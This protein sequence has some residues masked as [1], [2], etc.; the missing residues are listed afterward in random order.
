MI[1]VAE[2]V[3]RSWIDQRFSVAHIA[4][5]LYWS[6]VWLITINLVLFH[7]FEILLFGC[8]VATTNALIV[9]SLQRITMLKYSIKRFFLLGQFLLCEDHIWPICLE[10]W[11]KGASLPNSISK[12]LVSTQDFAVSTG[13]LVSFQVLCSLIWVF[14][15]PN[16][17]L[18]CKR[19]SFYASL[20]SGQR[21]RYRSCWWTLWS[22][23]ILWLPDFLIRTA[24]GPWFRLCDLAGRTI[25]FSHDVLACIN[26]RVTNPVALKLFECLLC[27]SA[28]IDCHSLDGTTLVSLL[29]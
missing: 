26:V 28:L 11:I 7:F 15:V 21:F 27:P 5:R 23:C 25:W 20:E 18:I 1:N 13:I 19:L 8:S 9:A 14:C 6:F 29:S 4:P 16:I 24:M 12:W 17:V 22:V 10:C 2:I 3:Q